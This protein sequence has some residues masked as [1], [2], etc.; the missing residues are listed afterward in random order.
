MDNIYTDIMGGNIHIGINW[1]DIFKIPLV[2]VLLGILLYSFLLVLRIK[3]L[4]DT[5]DSEG[6]KK[7]LLLGYV[8]L[9]VTLFTTIVG[10]IIILLA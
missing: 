6:N 7:M 4:V 9:L 10:T 1:I 5:V 3:I 2:V 8:N